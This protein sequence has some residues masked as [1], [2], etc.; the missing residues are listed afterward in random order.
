MLSFYYLLLA[1][2]IKAPTFYHD[3][4][5]EVLSLAGDSDTNCAIVGAMI[6]AYLGIQKLDPEVKDGDF[7]HESNDYLRKIIE[8]DCT[9]PSNLRPDGKT[10]RPNFL[11]IGKYCFTMMTDLL[12]YRPK[13]LS[14]VDVNDLIM[15]FPP[16]ME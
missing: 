10:E 9:D 1:D 14:G 8:F 5:K 7:F 16:S 12:S 3:A 11:N 15:T 2:V 4:M 6:G 13:D